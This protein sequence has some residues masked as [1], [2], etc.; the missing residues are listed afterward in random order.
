MRQTH[1]QTCS[2]C[3]DRERRG[4]G[5]G[6]G[7]FRNLEGQKGQQDINLTIEAVMGL[8]NDVNFWTGLAF[9]VRGRRIEEMINRRRNIVV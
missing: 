5:K 9:Y 3:A 4:G 2:L 7:E 8:S 1:K 6:S